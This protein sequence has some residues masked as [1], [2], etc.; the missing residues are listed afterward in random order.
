MA[1]KATRPSK[2]VIINPGTPAP[3][4]GQ[5]QPV[6]GGPEV[7]VPKGHRVPPTPN[8]GPVKLVDATKNKSGG[9]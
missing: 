9:K 3:Y 7:T 5:Y 8:G 4:S 1:K 2:S 6:N